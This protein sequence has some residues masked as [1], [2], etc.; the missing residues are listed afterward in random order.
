MNLVDYRL[1]LYSFVAVVAAA[2]AAQLMTLTAG[3]ELLILDGLSLLAVGYML[4]Y[5]KGT[6]DSWGGKVGRSLAIVAVALGYH[7]ILLFAIHLPYHTLGNPQ[8]LFLPRTFFTALA[9]IS[10]V[11]AFVSAAYG[12]YLLGGIESSGGGQ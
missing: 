6:V 9:H 2:V 1:S 4:Y 12:F 10:S 5:M 11:W 7:G 8:I 3:I